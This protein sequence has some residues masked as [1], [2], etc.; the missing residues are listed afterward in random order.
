MLF[1]SASGVARF[2]IERSDAAIRQLI[3]YASSSA[4]SLAEPG[5]D[6]D[7]VAGLLI[8][9]A[10][11]LR[12]E[13]TVPLHSEAFDR[14]G[15]ASLALSV[16]E[17]EL[18]D[19]TSPTPLHLVLNLDRTVADGVALPPTVSALSLEPASSNASASLTFRADTNSCRGDSSLLAFTIRERSSADSS[20][21]LRSY[22][23]AIQDEV[24]SLDDQASLHLANRIGLYPDRDQL[25][26][27]QVGAQL[28]LFFNPDIVAPTVESVAAAVANGL[29]GAGA[30]IAITVTFSE[31]VTVDGSGGTPRLRLNAG[32]SE[33]SALYA[34]GSGGNTLTF[35]YTVQPG[36]GATHLD[37]SSADALSL[38]GATLQDAAGNSANLTLPTPG[39][40]GSLGA[41]SILLIDGVAPVVQSLASANANGTYGLGARLTLVSHFSEPVRVNT[42]SGVPT[43][44]LETG[45]TDRVATYLAGSGT[46]SL[47]FTY[48]VQAGDTASDLDVVS[49]AALALNGA[50]LFDAAG[51]PADLTLP[52]PGSPGSLAAN[53]ALVVSGVVPQRLSISTATAVISEGATLAV[54]IS[55]D[56]LAPGSTTYWQFSGAG[57]TAGDFSPAGLSGAI[58]LGTD[59]RA[60]FSRSVAL[61][62]LAEGDEQLALEFFADSSHTRSLGRALF[63]IRDLAPVSVSGATDGRDL[64]IGTAAD[65]ILNGVPAVS[66]LNGRNSYDTLTGN[67]GNDLFVLGTAMAVF[68][69][70]G[71][72]TSAGATDLAAITD[73]SP[74]DRIQLH[75]SAAHYRLASGRVA[76]AAGVML[77]QLNPASGT[78]PGATD[79]LIG[80]VKG[81]TPASLTLSNPTQFVFV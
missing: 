51:N 39:A 7:P 18:L 30:V 44:Q 53:A 70:D 79:E 54:M 81:L 74:G 40:A 34:S 35:L 3:A 48:T 76:G 1:R 66:A 36:D 45:S 49:S 9:E 59:R 65:E 41:N 32:T 77:Y 11:E 28:T 26:N 78:L 43:L 24:A 13:I 16:E 63:T 55:S 20:D 5:R 56:T 15:S 57:I 22:Q 14:L 64:L 37:Y 61:D 31:A 23:A 33:R 46:D 38:Q 25:V 73:F 50:T 68:Y 4:D 71:I 58:T 75:G 60:A 19:A 47:S 29:Y 52:Q 27:H 80:F 69:D 62:A 2:A 21:T 8:L 12:K 72:A 10:G 42:A 6:Y 67:G 17:L